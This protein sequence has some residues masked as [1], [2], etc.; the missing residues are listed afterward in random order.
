M[1][2]RVSEAPLSVDD[3]PRPPRATRRSAVV[4]TIAGATLVVLALGGVLVWR[5]RHTV[6]RSTLAA[7]PQPVAFVEAKPMPFRESRTYVGTIEPWI[8]AKIGPQ[9]ISAYVLTVLV[10]P[11]DKVAKGDVVA[12]LDC[13]NPS[14]ATRAAEM[15]AQSID[16]KQRAV[17]D[18]AARVKSLLDGGFVALN[19][20]EQKSAQS[21]AELAQVMEAKAKLAAASLGVKDCVLRAPF[22]GEIASRVVDP[23]AFV[24]PGAEIVAIVDRQ[25]VRVTADV[26]EKDFDIVTVGAD[27]KIAAL[28]TGAT[29]SAKI[30]RRAPKADPAT[31]SVHFEVDVADPQRA[32]PVATTG[33]IHIDVGE[34]IPATEV[35]I[36][37]ATVTEEKAT[38]FVVD[39][40]VAHKREVTLIGEAG[41]A[42]F[43]SP[44]EL[45]AGAHVVTEGRALLADGDR[46]R[47]TL[48]TPA[49]ASSNG[50]SKARGGGKGR[51][52]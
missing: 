22:A 8:E 19:E 20:S 50:A 36:Y 25:T 44:A 40:N 30:S 32:L 26:P 49:P 9:Y 51:P 4:A 43:V 41:G 47:S 14:V 10:R 52:F 38:L 6:N 48:D 39:Q 7:A 12:T 15:Q 27:V 18:E 29:M 31:R 13:S 37:A 28:S 34:P 5:A 1:T 42:L 33:T 11:G 16:A 45:P 17:A 3:R 2:E 24:H 21:Q 23:G 46:V 35:P